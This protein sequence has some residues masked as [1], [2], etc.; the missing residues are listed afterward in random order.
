MFSHFFIDR[1]IF[2]AVISIL[3]SIAG[4]VAMVSLPIAQFPE[5][6]PPQVT[7]TANYPG[8][9]AGTVAQN[10]GALIENQVNGADNMIYMSSTSSSTGNYSLNV[11]FNIGTDVNLAQVDVQNRVNAT[12]PLLPQTVSQ[13]GVMVQKKSASFLMLIALYPEDERYD[14]DFVSNYA[15]IYVLDA[16]KRIPGANQASIFGVVDS[17]MRIWLSPDR[18]IRA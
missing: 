8:A 3:I 9:D 6:T 5:I 16:I 7:V 4:L 10:V 13:Q 15:N 12:L 14:E 1:P 17:A 18:M 11:F 2:A